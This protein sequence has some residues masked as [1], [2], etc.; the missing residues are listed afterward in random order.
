M[1]LHAVI[2]LLI[3]TIMPMKAQESTASKNV[4]SFTLEAP[5]LSMQK[6]DMGLP[7]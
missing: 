7:A 5:Q 2:F 6:K 3:T 1:K 4:S